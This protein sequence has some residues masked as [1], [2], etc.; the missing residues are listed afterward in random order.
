[1]HCMW[2]QRGME[3][4]SGSRDPIT[5]VTAAP[6]ML[7]I[8]RTSGE[9]L[10]YTLPDLMPAGN[11]PLSSFIN[12]YSAFRP[13]QLPF[14]FAFCLYNALAP[15]VFVHCLSIQLPLTLCLLLLRLCLSSYLSLMT[16]WPLRLACTAPLNI[17]PFAHTSLLIAFTAACHCCVP[18]KLSPHELVAT[19]LLIAFTAACHCRV[20]TK[21]LPHELV[22]WKA[23][24]ALHECA[25]WT[26]CSSAP[27]L[28]AHTTCIACLGTVAKLLLT[29]ESCQLRFTVLKLVRGQD[30]WL[31]CSES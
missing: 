7:L 12:F 15:F 22:A 2:L 16:S 9:V 26:V 1:M 28:N 4:F 18:T 30:R 24:S 31:D 21:L 25:Y 29:H 14:P 19:S 8:G 10:V 13:I 5:A 17:L 27:T 23:C 20:P 6:H 11:V 3:G